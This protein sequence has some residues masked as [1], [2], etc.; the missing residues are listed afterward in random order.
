MSISYN[1]AAITNAPSSF[2]FTSS[3]AIQGMFMDDPAIRN[4]LR[5]G[6]VAPAQTASLY[7]GMGVTVSLPTATTEAESLEAVLALATSEANLNG[8]TVFNQAAAMILNPSVQSP[9]PLAGG[10][11]GSGGT[12]A[13]APGGAI[14]FFELGSRARIWVA[15]S[16][17]VASALAGGSIT[18]AVYWDYTNQVLLSSPGG[19]ALPGVKVVRLS[20][21][22]NAMVVNSAGTGWNY[23]GFAALIEI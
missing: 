19:T 21:N 2:N 11:T 9:I 22:G 6:I 8:F 1:P 17:T 16:Q 10:G 14:N 23:S 20:T 18:Q 5:S 4:W 12:P 15:C 13:N 7:G 3:G